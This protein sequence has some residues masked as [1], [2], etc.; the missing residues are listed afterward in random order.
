MAEPL[1][2]NTQY[3]GQPQYIP[4]TPDQ[5][6]PQ[7]QASQ[8]YM[9]P[10]NQT[11]PNYVGDPQVNNPQNYEM[12]PNSPYVSPGHDNGEITSKRSNNQIFVIFFLSLLLIL[13]VFFTILAH[14]KTEWNF[15]ILINYIQILFMAI[16]DIIMIVNTCQRKTSRSIVNGILSLLI[17]IL[18]GISAVISMAINKEFN[19]LAL[20][21]FIFFIYL[22]AFNFK[23]KGCVVGDK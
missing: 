18:Y 17:T 10:Q 13:N 21:Y 11:D 9:S 7:L 4:L 20:F 22:I 23:A 15:S 1:M 19:I 16:L 2:P 5:N 14:F 6:N 3:Q 12:N 8:P